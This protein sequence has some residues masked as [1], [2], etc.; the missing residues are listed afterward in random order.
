MNEIFFVIFLGLL[1]TFAIVSG[2]AF[3][4]LIKEYTS[5]K[6]AFILSFSAASMM[7]I[8]FFELILEA[9]H[10]VGDVR[11]IVG[12]GFMVG[13]VFMTLVHYFV[14][15]ESTRGKRVTI[16]L[17]LLFKKPDL[18]KYAGKDGFKSDDR[19]SIITE[20]QSLTPS[21]RETYSRIITK[22]RVSPS[23]LAGDFGSDITK[24]NKHLNY[25]HE[26]N[27]IDKLTDNGREYY[28][29]DEPISIEKRI[30]ESKSV[31]WRT[32]LGFSLHDFPEGLTIG[33]GFAA[34]PSLG[35]LVAISLFVHNITEGISIASNF[36]RSGVK[37]KDI[38][39]IN[40]I[41]GFLNPLGAIAG[42]LIASSLSLSLLAFI[43]A[44]SAGL[45]VFIAV[46]DLLP[47][48][49][50]QGEEAIVTISLLIGFCTHCLIFM[51]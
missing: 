24:I 22:G 50:E 21:I 2:G 36:K 47:A 16:P 32:V 8:A 9:T 28:Y 3:I 19:S 18:L 38:I 44:F 48:A 26:H 33:A 5:Q 15:P 14:E 35:I 10:M 6:E 43:L 30:Q 51:L 17:R 4:G 23:E 40:C 49:I 39:K 34:A 45:F 11:Y 41:P 20:M 31:G 12:A 25:L 13:L 42:V 46:Q 1:Q 29:R 7:G 37:T 27:Y